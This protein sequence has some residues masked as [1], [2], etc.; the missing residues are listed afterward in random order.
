MSLGRIN[1]FA[2][3]SVRRGPVLRAMGL[4]AQ[5]QGLDCHIVEKSGYAPCDVAVVWGMPKPETGKIGTARKRQQFRHEIVERHRGPVVVLEA[6]VCG[7]RVTS[8]GRP[9]WLIRKLFPAN[10]PWT[11]KGLNPPR[12]LLDPFAHYRIG[13][14][15]FPDDGG[16]ALAPFCHNR[17]QTM[18]ES[19]GLPAMRPYR[20]EGRHIVVI[21][22]VPGDASL[23]GTD[24]HEWVL[25][26]CK[27]LRGMTERPILVRPHPLDH[28]FHS[29]G[30]PERLARM[31]A[32]IDDI[33]VPFAA[34]L[35]EAWSVV[36]YSSGAAIDALLNGVPAIA[37]SP[38]SFAWEVTDHSLERAIDPT[39]YERE[40]WLNRIA[41]SQWCE[42]EI[43]N[44]AVWGP[45]REALAA[46]QSL[47]TAAE[48]A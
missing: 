11:P 15:G 36:T 5:S 1:V 2:A 9:P 39:L 18:A 47:R 42:A 8:Q 26:S 41:A 24:I 27:A 46:A 40:A 37:V 44:G 20:K 30:M 14:G 3:T 12:S 23:R 33:S 7:R 34:S 13:L 25:A 32:G 19:L 48:A 22:Q 10:A 16:L 17:W 21:G 31:G 45:L 43:A 6:P 35:G 29:A 38:A 4:S 28:G